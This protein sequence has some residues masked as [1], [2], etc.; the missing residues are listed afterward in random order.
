MKV[1]ERMGGEMA[2]EKDKVGTVL[3]LALSVDLDILLAICGDDEKILA[4]TKLHPDDIDG[5]VK[6]L[7]SY[8]RGEVA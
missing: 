6:C 3:R 8:Q 7:Q 2:V 5:I 1:A 4:V